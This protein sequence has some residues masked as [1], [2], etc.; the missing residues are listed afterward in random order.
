MQS[1][2]RITGTLLT[3]GE[4]ASD[5]AE[6]FEPGALRWP[7]NGIVLRRQHQR[8]TPI[9]RVLPE[10]RGNQIVVDAPLPDTTAGR[11]A[12]AEIRAGLFKG[13]SVEFKATAQRFAG[14]VRHITGALLNGAGLVD[15]PSYAGSAVEVRARTARRRAVAVTLTAAQLAEAIRIG[16]TPEETAQATR[17]L[18]VATEAVTKHAPDAPDVVHDEAVIRVAGYLFDAPQA[19]QGTGYADI[20][21]NSGARAL[22]LPYRVHRAGSTGADVETAAAGYR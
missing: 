8:A 14:G 15:T 18:A 10:V 19:A 11:D 20:L 3:Y 2:G 9:M 12:A 7:D 4:R 13:L 5:R 21:R 6:M 17:L 16:A 1:P 22:L